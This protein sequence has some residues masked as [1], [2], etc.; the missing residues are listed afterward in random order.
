MA[1]TLSDEI[2]D[3]ASLESCVDVFM[4]FSKTRDELNENIQNNLNL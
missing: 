1:K 3:V 2:G 4:D